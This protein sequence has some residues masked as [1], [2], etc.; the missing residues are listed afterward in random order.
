MLR[1][2]FFDID[3]TLLDFVKAESVALRSALGSFGIELS[4]ELIEKYSRINSLQWEKLERGELS[5][6]EVLVS[7]FEIFFKELGITCSA[8]EAQKRYEYLLGVGHWFIDGAPELLEALYGRYRLY[9]VSNGT[10]SVQDR[11]IESAGIGKYFDGIF[12]SQCIGAD[13]PQ[14]EFFSRCFAQIEDFK[15]EESIILGDRLSSDILG[16]INA[17]IKTCWFNPKNEPAREGIV[18]DYEIK[19]LAEFPELIGGL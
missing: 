8:F 5:R 1:N 6:E 11:R 19:K 4:D 10:K 7:R 13:K 15:K 18:P 17:G 3:D 16:G 14:S 12:I 2:I 9:I